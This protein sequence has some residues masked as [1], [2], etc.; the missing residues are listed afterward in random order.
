M[1]CA[2]SGNV[3]KIGHISGGLSSVWWL[4]GF[5]K[6]PQ[7]FGGGENGSKEFNCGIRWGRK[8][9]KQVPRLSR[10]NS[11]FFFVCSRSF[12]ETSLPTHAKRSWLGECLIFYMNNSKDLFIS[13]HGTGSLTLSQLRT[14][15][16]EIRW[17]SGATMLLRFLASQA[18]FQ[19]FFL[20]A[21]S[22]VVFVLS[23]IN[24]FRIPD[25]RG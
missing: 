23:A 5:W 21:P 19:F 1:P 6:G 9:K 12:F 16:E 24:I 17:K 2:R 4:R 10:G 13:F 7:A 18:V 14:R 20:L 15:H 11:S 25:T 8:N 3:S 22:N